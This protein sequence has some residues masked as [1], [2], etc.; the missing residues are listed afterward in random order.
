M[1]DRIDDLLNLLEVE[2]DRLHAAELLNA[3]ASLER[4]AGKTVAAA[5]VDETRVTIV[6]QDGGRYHFYGFL[7]FEPAK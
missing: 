7:G 4:L 5:T 3:Q 1:K 2:P 6:T